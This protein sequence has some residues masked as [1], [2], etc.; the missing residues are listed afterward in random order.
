MERRTPSV[1]VLGFTDTGT[2]LS[3]LAEI[4]LNLIRRSFPDSATAVAVMIISVVA[5]PGFA[6]IF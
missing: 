3:T 2:G 6:A 4:V 5:V 1:P